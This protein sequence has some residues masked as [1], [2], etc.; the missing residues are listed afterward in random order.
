MEEAQLYS[1]ENLTVTAEENKEVYRSYCEG[2]GE[3]NY[4]SLEIMYKEEV[5]NT[6]KK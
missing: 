3:C 1:L 5:I 4:S 2:I 6:S